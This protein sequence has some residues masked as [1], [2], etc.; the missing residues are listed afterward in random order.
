MCPCSEQPGVALLVASGCISLM[1]TVHHLASSH[2]AQDTASPELSTN[3]TTSPNTENDTA[4][5]LM[6][7]LH[8]VANNS[9]CGVEE[10]TKIAKVILQ[11]TDKYGEEPKGGAGWP[12]TTW[13]VAPIVALLR[14]R[15]QSVIREAARRLVL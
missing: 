15:L 10:L 12:H 8:G 1:D 13:L 3:T 11:F 7:S 5:W 14:F 9:Q 6:P 2:S 4:V